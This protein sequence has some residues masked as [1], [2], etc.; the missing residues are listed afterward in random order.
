MWDPG[1]HHRHTVPPPVRGPRRPSGRRGTEA[2]GRAHGPPSPSPHHGKS[3]VAPSDTG[4]TTTALP[5]VIPLGLGAR[6]RGPRLTRERS[7]DAR[8]EA[9]RIG[10]SG[11]AAGRVGGPRGREPQATRIG[12][13]TPFPRIAREGTFLI[14]GGTDP[15]RRAPSRG[16]QERRVL[17]GTEGGSAVSVRLFFSFRGH[18]SSIRG[19]EEPGPR[20]RSPLTAG[21]L[22]H[23]AGSTAMSQVNKA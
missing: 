5:R 7:T 20:K 11:R 21:P 3:P 2:L 1:A 23:T 6:R 10:R 9:T 19:Q 15:T 22:K 16:G 8:G 12:H 13:S 17:A 14:E 18:T 4:V